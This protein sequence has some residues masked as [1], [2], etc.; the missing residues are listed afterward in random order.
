MR[1]AVALFFVTFYG[2]SAVVFMAVI[3]ALV[4]IFLDDKPK[5]K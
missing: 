5:K 1:K 2:I 4:I 3:E